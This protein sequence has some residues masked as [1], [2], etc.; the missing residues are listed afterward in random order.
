ME[1]HLELLTSEFPQ[2]KRVYRSLYYEVQSSQA[3]PSYTKILITNVGV[4][5][6]LINNRYLY[7]ASGMERG[8]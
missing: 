8:R 2:Q 1:H 6:V 5:I 7:L 3:S 4:A